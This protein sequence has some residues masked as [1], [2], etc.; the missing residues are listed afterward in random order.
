M[1]FK[2]LHFSAYLGYILALN[3]LLSTTH[4]VSRFHIPILYIIIIYIFNRKFRKLSLVG[5]QDAQS[6]IEDANVILILRHIPTL[7]TGVGGV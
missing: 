2:Q 6:S 1:I 4:A 7:W 5:V 3:N